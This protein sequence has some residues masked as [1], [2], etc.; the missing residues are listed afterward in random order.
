MAAESWV[1]KA[2]GRGRLRALARRMKVWAGW[3]GSEWERVRRRRAA[4]VYGGEVSAFGKK[5]GRGRSGS[6]AGEGEG[7]KIR[8]FIPLTYPTSLRYIA[9]ATNTSLSSL[10]SLP[11]G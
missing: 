4:I 1:W 8:T 11:P 5:G 10:S 7:N 3:A 9:Y 2:S 6:G